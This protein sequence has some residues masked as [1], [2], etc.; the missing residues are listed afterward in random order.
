MSD[1][2]AR[3]RAA[4][5]R[6]AW[7]E[8]CSELRA[9]DG[10]APLGADDLDRLGAATYLTGDDAAV[11]EAR[12]RAYEAHLDAEQPVRAAG[13]ALWLAAGILDR[14]D[15]QSEASGWIERARRLLDANPADSFELGFLQC[16]LARVRVAGGDPA[17][18]Y[19]LFTRAVGI[20][21]RLGHR[22]LINFARHGQGRTLLWLGR[23]AEGMTMLDEAMLAVTAGEVAPI[24]TGII[25][26]SAISA[27]HDL[28]DLRRAHEWTTALAG[29]CAAHPDML[30]F[31]GD[32]LIRRSELLQL[33][34]AWADAS[35]EVKRVCERLKDPEFEPTAGAAFYQ[36]GEL[37]RMRGEVEDADEAYRLAS[38]AGRTPQP[39]LALLR[40]QQGD[41]DG[42]D[43]AIRGALPHARLPR[44]RAFLLRAAVEIR[45]ARGDLAG[46]ADAAGQLA[47]LAG[48]E[49]PAYLHAASAHASG[50]IALARGEIE[51]AIEL[52]RD[53]LGRWRDLDAPYEVAR[54]RVL[55]GQAYR[56]LGDEEGAR[57]EFDAAL[58]IFE[59][60]GAAPD[61]VHVG[62]LATPPDAQPTGAL[63]GREVEVLRLVAEGK[64]N[65]TIAAAL[66]ISEK[67]V[68]R[69][70]S[71]IF[72]KL[73]LSSR[74]GATAYA[75]KHKLLAPSA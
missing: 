3:G 23:P 28:L 42:A 45:L 67:T 22:D 69:H 58:D 74:A 70:L 71:N 17:A 49:G 73:D 5:D 9:A 14:R 68:A 72:T 57:L 64:T 48:A 60:L 43:A 15:R 10:E 55:I 13:S 21:T 34:G 20:G 18:A 51:P 36:K 38:R 59:R 35:N 12:A 62:A 75:F 44:T 56:S 65:R 54:V 11:I 66:E 39:G 1:A 47:T 25:Y 27:C 30:A 16:V 32:C 2:L 53:A 19:E 37:C 50:S 46:A 33:H 7:A 4:W 29:W 40:L 41:A 6:Q 63:T 24:P 52:L 31:R 8:A 26:C 61:V